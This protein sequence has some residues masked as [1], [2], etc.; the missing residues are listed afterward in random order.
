[1]TTSPVS[2]PS[3]AVKVAEK[4]NEAVLWRFWGLSREGD[5]CLLASPLVGDLLPTAGTLHAACH[6]P[7]LPP[8]PGCICGVSAY[9][10]PGDAVR[11]VEKFRLDTAKFLI[12]A[13]TAEHPVIADY[14]GQLYQT[15]NMLATTGPPAVRCRA[16]TPTIAYTDETV[17]LA[18]DLPVLPASEVP[19]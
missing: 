17:E 8:W 3:E 1:M 5:K 9:R 13:G 6:R 18:Y 11:A 2:L 7:H 15:G 19:A 10:T 16:Y 14:A 12:T 4:A